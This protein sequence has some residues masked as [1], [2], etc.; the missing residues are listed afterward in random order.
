MTTLSKVDAKK[1]IV[2]IFRTNVKGQSPDVSTANCNHDGKVGHWLE[3][4]FGIWHNANNEADLYGF[5]L[6]TDT[7]AKITFGDWSANRYIF[8]NSRYGHI[9]GNGPKYIKQDKFLKI[10]WTSK[11]K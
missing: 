10:F 5:E 8:T 4:Q 9:F 7:G 3:K 6:K 2:E 11:S 1:R